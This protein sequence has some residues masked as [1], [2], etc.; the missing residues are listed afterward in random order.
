MSTDVEAMTAPSHGDEQSIRSPA[1]HKRKASSPPPGE[2]RTTSQSP[3]R[4]RRDS[5]ATYNGSTRSPPA[6]TGSERRP[7]AS[8]E[9]KK[10]G[11]RLFGGLLSTL[12]QKNSNSQQKRR[13]EIE[14]K[15]REKA[16]QLRAEDDKQR[17]AKLA[18]LNTVRK[19]EQ[20]KWD[21]K[22]M[23][24]KH[25]HLLATARFLRTRTVP[26][27]YYLPWEPTEDEEDIIKDQIRDAEDL[28]D[29]ETREFK[30]RKEQRLKALGITTQEAPASESDPAP[31]LQ[32]TESPSVDQ[33]ENTV[34]KTDTDATHDVPPQQPDETSETTNRD[35]A[36]ASK[37]GHHDHQDKDADETGDVMVEG[38]EDTVIY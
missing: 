21:E 37:G 22:V 26:Q 13:Q 29:S 19:R 34:G 25:D 33:D 18:E 3:K 35:S 24:T 28:I 16:S 11:Q 31:E 17:A 4:V 32:P 8:Q 14:R 38:D 1:A 6:P 5:E 15:Q 2:D 10:R 23:R 36:Q 30:Q 12:S 20:I 9:E 7:S 27:V